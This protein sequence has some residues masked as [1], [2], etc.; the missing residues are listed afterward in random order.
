MEESET[1]DQFAACFVI[2]VNRISGYGER[3]DEVKNVKRFLHDAPAR[4][5]QIITLVEQCL[6][7]EYTE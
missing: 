6:G 7:P 5:M 2:L 3:L 1:V 4:Y